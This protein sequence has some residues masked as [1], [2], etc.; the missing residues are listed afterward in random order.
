MMRA[1]HTKQENLFR[2]NE[3]WYAAISREITIS[4]RAECHSFQT[5]DSN[6]PRNNPSL[7]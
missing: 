5:D 2:F 6:T 3:E 7:I 1:I 4:R